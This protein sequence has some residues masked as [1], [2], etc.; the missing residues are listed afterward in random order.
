MMKINASTVT[1]AVAVVALLITVGT[2]IYQLG[3]LTNQVDQLSL[4]VANIREENR[5]SNRELREELREEI[6]R[7]N[8]Q[9]LYALA[10]HTHDADGKALFVIPPGSE[11]TGSTPN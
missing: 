4:Q 6:R 1:A 8:Q 9:I 11:P 2:G 3:Q 10:N 7:G 5:R